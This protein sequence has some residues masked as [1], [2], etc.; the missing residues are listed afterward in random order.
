MS[1]ANYFVTVYNTNKPDF[2]IDRYLTF[3]MKSKS[4]NDI[5]PA[6]QFAF[7]SY[8]EASQHY[9]TLRS[10]NNVIAKFEGN[11]L[12]IATNKNR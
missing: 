6:E 7:N 9:E 12:L 11:H 1:K 8:E 10:S 2:E 5:K 4:Q 3:Q